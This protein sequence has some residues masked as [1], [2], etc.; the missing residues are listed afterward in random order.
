VPVLASFA[1]EALTRRRRPTDDARVAR[2]LDALG[3]TIETS[4]RSVAL[5]AGADLAHMGPR[6]GDPRPITRAERARI[7]AEDRKMLEAVEQGDAEAFFDSVAAD[8]DRR[9]ICGLSPIYAVL[10]ALDGRRGALKRY[11]MWPDPEGIVSYA[12]V[13]FDDSA[14]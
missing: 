5:I 7:E 13:V 1:H 12:S 9:R 11:G 14:S 3:E 10:H 6:F 4:G 2:F 8:Q